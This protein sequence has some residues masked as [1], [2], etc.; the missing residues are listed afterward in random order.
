MA[1]DRKISIVAPVVESFFCAL[2]ASG[3]WPESIASNEAF[4]EQAAAR[5]RFRRQLNSLL[6]LLPRPDMTLEMAIEKGHVA[7]AQVAEIYVSLSE[8]LDDLDYR[9]LALYLP[10]EF[11]PNKNWR[12]SGV[13]GYAASRFRHAYLEAWRSLLSVRDV[14]A[15]FVDGDII[16]MSHR[17]GD[18]SRVVI[19]A[20]LIPKLVESGLMEA[21]D[22]VMLLEESKDPVLRDSLADTLPV[23]ADLGFFSDEE[24]E[25][26]EE[27]DDWLVRGVAQSIVFGKR[28]TSESEARSKKAITCDSVQQELAATFSRPETQD[29]GDLPIKRQKWLKRE[30]KRKAIERAGKEIGDAIVAGSFAKEVVSGLTASDTG[31]ESCVALIEGIRNAIETVESADSERALKLYARFKQVL[32]KLLENDNPE[33]REALSKTFRRFFRLGIVN[34]KLLA[35]MEIANP[36]LAGPFS[37]NLKL[38]REEIDDIKAMTES[39]AKHQELSRLI[40]PIVLVFGSRLKGYGAHNAD[41]DLA[42]FVRPGTPFEERRRLQEL[43]DETFGHEL[44]R[45]KI[46]E[47]WLSDCSDGLEIIDFP[48]PDAALGESYWVHILFGAAWLGEEDV[49][50]EL[51]EKLLASYLYDTGKTI[52]GY[53]ARSVYL[54]ELERDTLQFRLMHKGYENFYPP[55]GG[56][57]VSHSEGIDGQSVFWDSGYRQL[58]TRLFISQVFLP[59]IPVPKKR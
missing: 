43:L 2:N 54:E 19:A 58:A 3:F 32:L 23:L 57:H 46:V 4:L 51:A 55:Y 39:I 35:E 27:S 53:D 6:V 47:F 45:D 38:I 56:I 34:E 9:R 14:R 49:I 28:K 13:L 48:D 1:I 12:P 20:H 21:K 7:E 30:M 50:S 10:F 16:E 41:I 24:L 22:A 36:E 31:G 42:V 59:K 17:T 5:K 8:L 40:Y 26:M 15:N 25:S 11:L 37:K 18:L 33:V 52:D 44:V 29:F